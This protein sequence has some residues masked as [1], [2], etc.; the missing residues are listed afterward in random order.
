MFSH[1]HRSYRAGK[2]KV[3]GVEEDLERERKK[4]SE[5]F[6]EEDQRLLFIKRLGIHNRHPR[7]KD[8]FHASVPEMGVQ[9]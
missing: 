7:Q 1:W 8:L 4:L 6:Q 5:A 2:E 3:E 9:F